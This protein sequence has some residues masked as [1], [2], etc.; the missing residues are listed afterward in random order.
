M[1][2]FLICCCI[3]HMVPLTSLY[4]CCPDQHELY[5]VYMTLISFEFMITHRDFRRFLY[6]YISLVGKLSILLGQQSGHDYT[7]PTYMHHVVG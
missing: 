7:E 1:T 4:F 6:R 3:M 2:V 5:P